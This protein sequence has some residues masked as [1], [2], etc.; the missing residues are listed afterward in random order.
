MNSKINVQKE[1]F[2]KDI[3]IIKINQQILEPKKSMNEKKN[4]LESI[5]NR[6]DQMEKRIRDL[7]DVNVEMI[8]LKEKRDLRFF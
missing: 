7:E 5:C 2:T 4:S 1:F 3:K 6:A 8:Q